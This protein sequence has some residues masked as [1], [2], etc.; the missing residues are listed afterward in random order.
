MVIRL[1][2]RGRV[3]QITRPLYGAE[4]GD[5]SVRGAVAAKIPTVSCRIVTEKC[6]ERTLYCF[7]E[8]ISDQTPQE[9]AFDSMQYESNDCT[10][11]PK[12]RPKICIRGR[13]YWHTH[14]KVTHTRIHSPEPFRFSHRKTVVVVESPTFRTL[15]VQFRELGL[16]VAVWNVE[17]TPELRRQPR[18]SRSGRGSRD[19]A[20]TATRAINTASKS[21]ESMKSDCGQ[22]AVPWW[23]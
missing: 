14:S 18:N 16:K 15:T 7:P 5:G 17:P 11:S 19:T 1:W 2:P 8:K 4:R 10:D 12:S 20:K 21:P 6:P 22:Y 13:G 3:S 9:A 23:V